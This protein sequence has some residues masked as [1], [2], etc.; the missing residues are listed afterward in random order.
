MGA[1]TETR[2]RT[3]RRHRRPFPA[4]WVTL[5]AVLFVDHYHLSLPLSNHLF[6]FLAA[7]LV[8]FAVHGTQ[9]PFRNEI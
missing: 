4:L 2:N 6:P 7:S 1:L 3:Q 9:H 8:L 5:L